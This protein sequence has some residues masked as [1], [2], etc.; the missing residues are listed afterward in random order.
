MF[1][2]LNLF[3]HKPFSS[4]GFQ[5]TS[6]VHNIRFRSRDFLRLPFARTK[7]FRVLFFIVGRRPG[8]RYLGL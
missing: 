7:K 4:G 1:H 3:L 5:Q 2:K 8:A 6:D